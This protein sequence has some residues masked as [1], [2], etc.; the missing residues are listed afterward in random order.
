VCLATCSCRSTNVKETNQGL[1]GLCVW[2]LV[3]VDLLIIS[4]STATSSQTHSPTSPW[5]VSLTL[6]DLQL[7]VAKHT[8]LLVFGVKPRTSRTVC[9]ATCSCRSTNVKETNQG[10][11][12]LCVWLLVAVDLLMLKRQTKD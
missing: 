8:V 2:L 4:R 3:A 9:L 10:L 7:Q 11:V 12:G 6:V 5:F 1:V